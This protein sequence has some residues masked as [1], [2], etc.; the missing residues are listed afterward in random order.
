MNKILHLAPLLCA[1][2]GC[3][4][5]EPTYQVGRTGEQLSKE[6]AERVHSGQPQKPPSSIELDSP[7][8]VLE[9]FFPEYPPSWRKAGIS[10]V[11]NVRFTVEADGSVSNP[12]IEGSPRAEL[13]ALTLHSIMRWKFAPAI[14]GGAAVRAKAQQKFVYQLQ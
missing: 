9:S 13:A 10:G 4:S 1:L 8:R 3:A 12:S 11:V 14:R 7:P 2:A 5:T 6:D